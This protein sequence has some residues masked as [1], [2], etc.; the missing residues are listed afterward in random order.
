MTIEVRM[1]SQNGRKLGRYNSVERE[2]GF[3]VLAILVRSKLL[4]SDV[5]GEERDESRKSSDSEHSERSGKLELSKRV[6][7]SILT[8]VGY[9]S[10]R[11][12]DSVINNPL[13]Y[14]ILLVD[15]DVWRSSAAEV[16]KLYYEQFIVF[17]QRSK[18]RQFNTKRLSRMRQ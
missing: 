10:E 1:R 16:Q 7:M 2:N 3:G 11:L 5:R 12:E 9:Q 13:A 18:F 4:E 6:L 8:F 14:R 15:L 17:A